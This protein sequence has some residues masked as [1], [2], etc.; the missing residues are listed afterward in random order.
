MKINQD[1]R[2]P[3]DKLPKDQRQAGSA[4]ARFAQMVQQHDQKLHMEQ[5]NQLL[6]TIG[7]AGSRLGHSRSFRDLAKYK[8]LVKKFLKEAVDYGVELQESH[9]WNQFGEGRKLRL[10]ETIDQH[11]ID[12]A[13]A[14]MDQERPSI[15]ILDKIGEIK[16]LLINLYR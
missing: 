3:V 5:L 1:L 14:V 2:I 11:L 7:N 9:T 4:Q 12:L 13:E 8:T 6:S 10:V 15:D 16:G